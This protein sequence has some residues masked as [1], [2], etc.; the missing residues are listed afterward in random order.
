MHDDWLERTPKTKAWMMIWIDELSIRTTTLTIHSLYH[1]SINYSH[2]TINSLQ[3]EDLT[4]CSDL[5]PLQPFF[6]STMHRPWR[7]KFTLICLHGQHS[8]SLSIILSANE[9]SMASRFTHLATLPG[10]CSP[11]VSHWYPTSTSLRQNRMNLVLLAL[12]DP[13]LIRCIPSC[14]WTCPRVTLKLL[15]PRSPTIDTGCFLFAHRKSS[16]LSMNAE[17]YCSQ[18]WRWSGQPWQPRR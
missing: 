7:T 6:S 3:N 17:S 12:C 15:S 1:H 9:Y 4:T 16:K 2:F 11:Q 8:T 10:L 5:H 14:S 13:M 18:I